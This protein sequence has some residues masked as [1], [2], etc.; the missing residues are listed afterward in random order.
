MHVFL[1]LSLL[2]LAACA[3]D[4]VADTRSPEKPAEQLYEEAMASFRE[5]SYRK[6]A[7]SFELIEQE[8]PQSEW[9]TRGKI[10]AAYSHFRA[11]EYEDCVATLESYLKLHPGNTNAP[12]A[13]Y[14]RA[15]AYYQQITDVGRD[16][17]VTQQ[18]RQALL[19]VTRLHP[20]SDYARDAKVK[21]DLV[22]DH[23]AGKEMEVGRYYLNQRRYVAGINRFRTVLEEYQTTSHT[24]EA[25]HRMTEAYLALGVVDE[26]TRYAAVLG[27]NYPGNAWY[28]RSYNLL[29]GSNH[30]LFQGKSDESKSLLQKLKGML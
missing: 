11:G 23:L 9:A 3:S 12:Y 19:D 10:M 30:P 26:A 2:W 28:V 27:H 16:Q 15:L 18:A 7:E 1:L 21:L 8:K 24:P 25:L 17:G 20:E 13:R 4:D 5:G 6:A 22:A 14:L 29:T